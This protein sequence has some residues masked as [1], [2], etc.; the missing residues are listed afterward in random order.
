MTELP[1]L[2]EEHGLGPEDRLSV[3]RYV[4][5]LQD[6][7]AGGHEW[8]TRSGRY[9]NASRNSTAESRALGG[10]TGLG[11][12]AR[13]I[14]LSPGALG[15][16]RFKSYTHVPYQAVG[17]L[18]LLEVYM[19]FPARLNPNLDA[20][21]R[22]S[23]EWARRMGMLDS[24]PGVPGVGIWDAHQ[25]DIF[26]LALCGAMIDPHAA[27]PKLDLTADWLVWGTYADDYFPAIYGRTRDMAGAKAFNERLP[28]FMP[29]DLTPTPPRPRRR[30]IRWRPVWP[31]CGRQRR[32]R[33]LSTRGVNSAVRSWT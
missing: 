11:T 6:W 29:L 2:F 17:R 20:A 30:P 4:K 18:K 12:S 13:R 16:G 21:R 31:T 33:S 9:M 23:K 15:L 25:F 10:P 8:H 19:P 28:A 14:S 22:H 3:L 5:G 32:S 7:Q 1:P 27:A 24:E 26:D